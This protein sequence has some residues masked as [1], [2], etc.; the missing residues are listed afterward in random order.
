MT[1]TLLPAVRRGAGYVRDNGSPWQWPWYPW[2]LFVMLG[3]GVGLRSYSLCISFHPSRGAATMFEPYFFVPFLFAINVLLLEIGIA[4]RRPALLRRMMAAPLGLLL[5]STWTFTVPES[6]GLR[7]ML[8]DAC[9]CSPLFLTLVATTALYAAAL[10]RRVPH[11]LHGLTMA[12]AA[13]CRDRS[14]HSG[15]SGPFT[16]RAWPLVL[17]AAMQLY[18]TVRFRSGL[19]GLLTAVCT[20]AALCIL[21]PQAIA[22]RYLR[23]DPRP[24]ALV[25]HAADRGHA[26]GPCGTVS[27]NGRPF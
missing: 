4:A 7:P 17:L 18:A 10:V 5:L 8:L 24:S 16:L 19:H 6:I 22:V 26:A 1:L 2:P 20:L 13:V 9:G 11:A 14:Q 12:T 23:G 25:R 21:W 27:A 15:F 3:V